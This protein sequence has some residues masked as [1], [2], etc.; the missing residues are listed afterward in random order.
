MPEASAN[1]HASSTMNAV[2]RLARVFERNFMSGVNDDVAGRAEARSR[3][4]LEARP[5][6]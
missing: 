6:Q 5:R 3:Y 4:A 1:R 2:W